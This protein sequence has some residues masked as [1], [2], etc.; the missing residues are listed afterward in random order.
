MP[1]RTYRQVFI[2]PL[3]DFLAT[4]SAGGVA[5][6]GAALLALVWANSPWQASYRELWSSIVELR[7]ASFALAFDLR[8]FVNEGLMTIF[9]L[10]VGLEIKR[11]IV[12]G[13]LREPSAR[14]LPV[15][16]AVGGMVVPALIYVGL[17]WGRPEVQ[18]WGVPI[19]TDIAL[20][21][22]VMSLAKNASP[23]LKV[24]LLALAIVDDIG[25]IFVIGVVYAG[26]IELGW[27]VAA[28]L[29]IA[30]VV[31][32]QRRGVPAVWPYVAAGAGLWLALHEAGIHAT[33]AG[34]TLGLLAPTKPHLGPELIDQTELT[35]L[36][37][38][39]DARITVEIARSSV[40]VVEWVEHRLHPWTSYLIVPVFALANAGVTLSGESV[41]EAINSPVAWGVTLGLLVGKPLGILIFAALAVRVGAAAL[42]A[43]VSW[44][45]ILGAGLVAGMGFTVSLFV[46][47]LAL[48]L[49]AA[50]H[51]RLGIV[52]ASI[53]AGSIGL[54]VLRLVDDKSRDS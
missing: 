3:R 21:L 46:A 24:F 11:E 4:E 32:L 6:V 12:E 41:R 54:L 34:V 53:L 17:N 36:G 22:G 31:V 40:S 30:L 8:G 19:A 45:G 51:A 48:P 50:D 23:R 9:F 5:I 10:V 39:R 37:T 49:A 2:R 29:C 44:T 33:L 28:C 26:G 14:S 20:A 38:A 1:Q 25:A 47:Q 42:P 15:L 27:I 16:A 43:G 52:A 7:V 13:E 18:G 35:S